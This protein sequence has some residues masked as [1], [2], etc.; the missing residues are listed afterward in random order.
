[1]SD[2]AVIGAG[3]V[4]LTTAVCFAHLGHQVVC[5]DTD[6]ERVRRLRKGEVPIREPQLS[7]LVAEGLAAERLSFTD[8]PVAAV[9][10]AEFV[11][12]CVPTPPDADGA[13]DLSGL[14]SAVRAVAP[15]LAPGTVLVSKSTVPVGTA[16]HIGRTLHALDVTEVGIASNPEFLGEGSAV[17]HFLNPHRVVIGADDPAVAVRVSGLYRGLQAPVLVTDTAS[18]EVIKYTSNA[19]LATKLSFVNEVANLCEATN[20][21][22]RD[23]VTGM[24]YDPRIGFE[25]LQPGPGWGGSCLPKDAAAL[26]HTADSAGY[27]FRLLRTAVEVNEEQRERV[28][29]K[30]RHACDDRLEDTSVAVWGLTFK[31]GTDDLRD[32]PAL[33]IVRRLRAEGAHVVAYDP[34]AGEASAGIGL[35]VAADPYAACTGAAALAVLTEWDEFRWLD[36]ARVRDELAVPNVIDARNLLD[37]N[38]MR[39]LGFHYVA[40]GR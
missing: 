37:A 20:A 9:R 21:D 19:F 34:V 36:F 3:Y 38:A 17:R 31:A 8:D 33:D 35:D 1:M 12:L 13:A 28:V 29:A 24:G 25:Y 23:V 4:G 10:G 14:D 30:I 32:S 11:F 5:A 6:R 15:W 22:V 16:K 27:K 18:A 2:I 26:L 39:R 7:E 40:L